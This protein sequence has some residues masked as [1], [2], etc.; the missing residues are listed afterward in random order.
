MPNFSTF[1]NNPWWQ[2]FKA[3]IWVIGTT[4][5]IFMVYK[6]F[7]EKTEQLITQVHETHTYV[8]NLSDELKD[9]LNGGQ[10]VVIGI[11]KEVNDYQAI[12]LSNSKLPYKEG[13]SIVLL[14]DGSNYK[15]RIKLLI[16][17]IINPTTQFEYDGK[18]QLYINKNAVAMLDFS[19]KI[20]TKKLKIMKFDDK[21][22]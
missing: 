3:L 6:G 11:S 15:P 17:S 9:N 4:I 7:P 5:T 14:N 21:K 22:K 8:K 2:T 12:M 10:P 18:L 20:G 1:F 16:S 19:P 13:D